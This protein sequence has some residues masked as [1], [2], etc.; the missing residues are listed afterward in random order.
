MFVSRETL[1]PNL[2]QLLV[3][4]AGQEPVS[5]L[6]KLNAGE[7]TPSIGGLTG[8]ALSL[9]IS[10]FWLSIE[11]TTIFIFSDP[12]EAEN[13]YI[14]SFNLIGKQ[15]QF[16][17]ESQDTKADVPGFISGWERYQADLIKA[18]SS[19]FTGSIITSD[20]S[21]TE[22]VF[23][24][25]HVSSVKLAASTSLNLDELVQTLDSWGFDRVDH[26]YTP[27][28]FAVRGGIID[29][30]SLT[31]SMP[32][33]IEFFGNT[34]ESIRSF[35]PVSQRT[36]QHL[37]TVE[38]FP[39]PTATREQK[40]SLDQRITET[41]TRFYI[42]KDTQG[43]TIG[44]LPKSDPQLINCEST[45]FV[46]HSWE[47]KSTI[48]NNSFKRFGKQ[49]VF[50]FIDTEE[51]RE[52]VKKQLAFTP[53]FIP[54][55]LSGSVILSDFN[56]VCFSYSS[57]FRSSPALKK[58][59]AIP[60]VKVDHKAIG[61]LDSIGW[62]DRLVH[63]DFGIGIYRGLQE[64]KGRSATQ[65]CI[66]IEY[67]DNGVVYVPVD[68]FS[69]VHK[70]IS[71]GDSSPAISRLGTS[72]WEKQ[73]LRTKKSAAAVVNEL[74]ELY[75]QRSKPRG[76]IYEPDKEL[77]GE[78]ENSFP[79]EETPDQAQAII[80]VFEDFK[81]TTPMDRLVCGDVGF[82][83]TEVA[84]RAALGAVSSGYKVA[85]LAPTTVL[86]DQHYLTAENRLG[87]LG[88]R[89]ELLSRYKNKRE[90]N[91]ITER[92][93]SGSIDMV[94]GTHRLLSDDVKIPQL[95]LLI[96]DE[97]HRF[98]VKHKEKIK[99]IKKNIDV[100]TLTATPIP[101]TL[102]QSLIGVRDI[103]KIETPPKERL[104][105][106]T[107]IVQYDWNTIHLALKRELDRG[108]QAFFLHNNIENL[109]FYQEQL[110]NA[111]PSRRVAFA[112][113]QMPSKALEKT[114]L[115]FFDGEIDILV[116]TTIIES[117]LDIPNVNTIIINDAQNFGLAQIYQIRGRV[118]RSN[119]QAFCYLMIPKNFKLTKNAYQRLKAIEYFSN[120]G[121]GYDIALKDLE[122]RGA[123]NMFGFEQSGQVAAVGF[124]LYC[125]ILKE[126]VDEI[127]GNQSQAEQ[128]SP[129]MVFSEDALIP[130]DYM[131]LVQDRLFFYQKL[132]NLQNEVDLRSIE[133]ELEDRFGRHPKELQNLFFI[134][135]L[136]VLSKGSGIKSLNI[137]SR[138]IDGT[139]TDQTRFS[140][141]MTLL[142]EV[143]SLFKQ[144][145]VPYR[146]KNKK[147]NHFSFDLSTSDISES[148]AIATRIVELFSPIIHG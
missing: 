110:Q 92:L 34:V 143:D 93:L 134:T 70:Y 43:Y 41:S 7:N 39:P 97:E 140:D 77:L 104:P 35:N 103:S 66:K 55:S 21:F 11:N 125:K 139:V 84:L 131:E 72:L 64:V 1:D 86:A 83:K 108:G 37:K 78:L 89:V 121:S 135:K 136:R 9:I 44:V 118:G 107:A 58:R 79:F 26:V 101:R 91:K 65:E 33:R 27:K 47:V 42:E 19:G 40:E 119:R 112:H 36:V 10:S 105:V 63:K 111:F 25:G 148:K 30:F 6:C 85:L 144:F 146:F 124:E 62:G 14:K 80:S 52:I 56:I 132:A 61:S 142:N 122:I 145:G 147:N 24:V 5:D 102:Q 96:V 114:M 123:G 94:V 75:A 106:R 99:Q 53:I 71:S 57:L 138:T 113:G 51:Q 90:Q 109:V 141:P 128:A 88:V 15:V 38:L 31:D 16:L 116:C 133:S 73:K 69:K 4:L 60:D 95:G 127:L 12:H 2:R 45:S 126:S 13:I 22:P 68:K 49:G 29:L 87:Q 98:G 76:F 54:S 46:R 117:G 137:N 129:H 18:L 17:P 50:F 3:L 81:R 59:W 48:L 120:L 20:K 8:D 74:V 32:V 100:L 67:A 82:G 23:P 28:S 130:S 115:A